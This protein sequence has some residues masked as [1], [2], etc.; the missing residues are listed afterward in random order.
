MV[1][2]F[3]EFILVATHKICQVN[4]AK[5]LTKNDRPHGD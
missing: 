2:T 3:F 5:Y 4:G 1:V